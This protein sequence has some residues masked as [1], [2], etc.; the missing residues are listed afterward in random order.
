MAYQVDV[1]FLVKS[2][3]ILEGFLLVLIHL[4]LIVF[5]AQLQDIYYNL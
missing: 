4:L 3:V 2:L 5:T 1:G